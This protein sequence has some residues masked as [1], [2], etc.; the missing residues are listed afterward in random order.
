MFD[1]FR[2]ETCHIDTQ[3]GLAKGWRPSEEKMGTIV[4]KIRGKW[5]SLDKS[6][7]MV[8]I[9]TSK[10]CLSVPSP[11]TSLS[12]DNESC[13]AGVGCRQMLGAARSSG[14]AR[15]AYGRV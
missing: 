4:I 14:Q 12:Q 5:E 15:L 9:D 7:K 1:E 2:V 10:S 13:N 8:A 11:K 3:D 6:V